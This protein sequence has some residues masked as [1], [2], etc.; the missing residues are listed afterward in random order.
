M[1][2]GFLKMIAMLM[3]AAMLFAACASMVERQSGNA[4]E[5][6]APV[7]VTEPD[8]NIALETT[9]V[10]DGTLHADVQMAA[11]KKVELTVLAAASL[12]DV[13]DELKTQF[14]KDNP[15]VTINISYGGSGALQTQIEEGVPADVFMSAAMKQMTALDDEGLMDS[16]SILQLL[17]NK[18]VMIVPKESD[19]SVSSF[20]DAATDAVTMIGLGEPGSVPVGQYSEEIFN[21]LGILDAVKEKANYGSDVRT[22]LSWVETAAVDCGVVYAT[23]AYTSEDV[24]IVCEAPEGS[25][26]KVLYPVGIVAASE[27]PDEAAAWLAFIQSE[28]SMELFESYGFSDAN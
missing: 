11:A 4:S 2:N 17:E 19:T 12:T 9:A 20:E 8:N 7:G 21:S 16:D 6:D 14:E 3:A 13:C 1:N 28:A 18:V 22:V 26:S 15:S 10:D 23:D 5:A 27:H 25:C 24:R